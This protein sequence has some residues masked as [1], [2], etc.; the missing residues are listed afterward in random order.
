MALDQRGPLHDRRWLVIDA[1]SARF[2]TQREHPALATVAARVDG[3]DLIVSAPGTGGSELRLRPPAA[4][5]APTQTEIWGRTIGG[6]DVGDDAAAWF[7]ELLGHSVRL[8][9]DAQDGQLAFADGYPLLVTNRASLDDL[10]SRLERPVPM[11]R[12]RPNLVVD[13][14]PA[15]A[16]DG[17][18]ELRIGAMRLYLRKPC[19]RCV[20]I[21][22]DQVT[23][24]VAQEPLRVLASFRRAEGGGAMFGVNAQHSGPGRVRVGDPIELISAGPR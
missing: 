1:E 12:F 23:G 4:D 13:G 18:D 10:N 6:H 3:A 16:E 17:W 2:I 19:A 7:S 22:T 11:E 20:V 24:D 8:L 5:G 9:A 15:W 14:P 21:N